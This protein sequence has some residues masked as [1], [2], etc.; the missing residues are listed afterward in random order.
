MTDIIPLKPKITNA[1]LA[2]IF[3]A[4][5]N[6]FEALISHVAFGD[7]GGTSYQP[8]GAETALRGERARV[9][10][11]GGERE[12][13]TQILVQ[14][15]LDEGPEFWMREV[16]FILNDGTPLAIWSE[17]DDNG[18][19]LLMAFKKDGVPF[20]FA[21]GLALSGVPG[22]SV[23]VQISG[24]AVNVVFDREFALIV[25]NQARITRQQWNFNEAFYAQHG[26]YPGGQS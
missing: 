13:P 2:A 4:D 3:N 24:P 22:N 26:H 7:G 6:G 12:A 1:G 18:D 17:L 11:G 25:A 5:N 15:V 9:A 8:N 19:D 16:A 10:I 23:N 21:Y 20:I 14:G